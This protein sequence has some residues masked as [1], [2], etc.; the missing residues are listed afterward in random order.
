MTRRL[1]PALLCLSPGDL[2]PGRCSSFVD[3][4]RA[5]LAAGP[6]GVLVRE[7]GLEDRAISEL[8]DQ[9]AP[10]VQTAGGWLGVHDR[11]HVASALDLAGAHLGYQSLAPRE[12]R[13]AFG[14]DLVLGYST[15]AG[16]EPAVWVGADYVFH[17]PVYDTPSKR[18]LKDPVGS[19][20]L[21]DF[22]A[23]CDVPVWAIG[24]ISPERAREVVARGARGVAA[25]SGVLGAADPAG[26]AGA[27]IDAL[28][29]QL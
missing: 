20:A 10:L 16:E 5:A 22:C 24:G 18:G 27:Y 13:A 14:E 6:I 29:G 19:D 21:A 26:A 1:P 11:V 12:V 4:V 3:R 7:P 23:Q 25:L 8:L 17:G 9:L 15:H 28:G 2:A